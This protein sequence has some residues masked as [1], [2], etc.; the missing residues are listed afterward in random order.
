[1]KNV[2]NLRKL[3]PTAR[4]RRCPSMSVDVSGRLWSQH[5]ILFGLLQARTTALQRRKK[6]ETR[7]KCHR[8][9]PSQSAGNTRPTRHDTVHRL[10]H[11]QHQSAQTHGHHWQKQKF[12]YTVHN[13]NTRDD[14]RVAKLCVHYVQLPL[15][16]S[17]SIIHPSSAAVVVVVVVVAARRRCCRR[18]AWSSMPVEKPEPHCRRPSPPPQAVLTLSHSRARLFYREARLFPIHFFFFFFFF[19]LLLIPTS[20]S[21]C[22]SLFTFSVRCSVTRR[23]IKAK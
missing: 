1:M 3:C 17:C 13:T 20:L 4:S 8:R 5:S 12:Y 10:S 2:P 15:L 23:Q 7:A 16:L 14:V 6:R 22:I 19:F 9:S 18:A 21:T 11:K